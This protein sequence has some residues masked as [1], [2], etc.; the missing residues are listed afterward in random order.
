[1]I[2]SLDAVMMVSVR[3]TL[4]ICVVD[5]ETGARRHRYGAVESVQKASEETGFTTGAKS[6]QPLTFFNA[7]WQVDRRKRKLV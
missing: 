3:T 2:A 6:R 7:G 5:A 4:R 1:M